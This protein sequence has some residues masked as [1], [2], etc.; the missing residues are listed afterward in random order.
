MIKRD[1]R[2][3]QTKETNL[4]KCGGQPKR[5]YFRD[6]NQ[7]HSKR[8]MKWEYACEKDIYERDLQTRPI[9][10]SVKVYKKDLFARHKSSAFEATYVVSVYIIK[11]DLRKRE[12][13]ETYL[14]KCAGLQ[15]RV[16]NE[17]HVKC[18]RSDICS[19]SEHGKK[20]LTKETNKQDLLTQVWRFSV[21][22]A[23][24]EVS[25]CMIKRHLREG[26]TKKTN[27]RKCEGLQKG[28]ISETQIKCIRSDICSECIHD[29]KRSTK[30]TGKR[31]LLTQVWRSTKKSY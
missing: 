13:K 10:T 5:T 24:Y 22:E 28:L 25:V 7:V 31:D 23:T 29:T 12:A 9:Y 1:L 18:I 8:D 30:E 16:I 19:E 2:K 11:R 3:R 27:L 6:T 20:R 15:K 14:H 26:Q 17:T 21:F 4:H